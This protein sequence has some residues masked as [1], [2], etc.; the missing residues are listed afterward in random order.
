MGIYNKINDNAKLN[1]TKRSNAHKMVVYRF[2][3]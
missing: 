1:R 3:Y 2:F